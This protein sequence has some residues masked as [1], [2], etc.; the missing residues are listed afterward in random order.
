MNHPGSAP[1]LPAR[2]VAFT[3]IELLVVIAIIALLIGLLLPAVQKVREAAARMKCQ[4]NMKQLGIALHNYHAS[5]GKFPAGNAK[6]A[7]G[8]SS[9]TGHGIGWMVQLLPYIEQG[10]LASQ[11]N[12]SRSMRSAGSSV[13]SNPAVVNQLYAPNL[14]CPSDPDAGLFD[15]AREPSYLPSVTPAG[16]PISTLGVAGNK[17]LGASYA[18]SNGPSRNDVCQVAAMNPNINCYGDANLGVGAANTNYGN[19]GGALDWGSPGMFSVGW[20]AYGINECSDGTS[21]TILLG[22]SLPVYTTFMMYFASHI[23]CISTNPVPN[24]YVHGTYG[25]VKSPNARAP[26]GT[27]GVRCYGSGFNSVHPGGLNICLTDGSVRY[28]RE[29]IDYT[30]F[31]YLGNRQDGMPISGNY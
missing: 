25:C 11:Y 7:P 22:E 3:L 27:G 23:N 2:R 16:A 9:G 30:T 28:M 4:N 12:Y 10:P 20:I 5:V 19:S 8:F 26:V 24:A 14:M 15:N 1:R 31:Q 13:T 21:N 17:S 6:P 29:D 18:P